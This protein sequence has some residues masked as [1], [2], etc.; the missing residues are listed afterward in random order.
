MK[1]ECTDT[2]GREQ[3][4]FTFYL[5]IP[6]NSNMCSQNSPTG[7]Y[8]VKTEPFHARFQAHAWPSRPQVPPRAGETNTRLVG[9]CHTENLPSPR[10]LLG[11][12]STDLQGRVVKSWST[13]GTSTVHVEEV[14]GRNLANVTR[15]QEGQ[16]ACR[17]I[18][19]RGQMREQMPLHVLWRQTTRALCLCTRPPVPASVQG[20]MWGAP[21]K[22]AKAAVDP[23][24]RGHP[25]AGSLYTRAWEEIPDTAQAGEEGVLRPKGRRC[26]WA[27]S[28]RARRR[29]YV[30]VHSLPTSTSTGRGMQV[31][32]ST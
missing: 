30:H 14:Q 12:R 28:V 21:G 13:P 32:G 24:C 8:L 22:G 4:L 5:H 20:L 19:Y 31:H 17:E 7:I 1:V 26:V 29:T 11:P 15:L 18:P 23:V 2:P 27:Y 9:A 3:V 6:V 10:L 25:G 16:G